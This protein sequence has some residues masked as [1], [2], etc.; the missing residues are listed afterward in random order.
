[1][2]VQ[3]RPVD[4]ETSELKAR[5]ASAVLRAADLRRADLVTFVLAATKKLVAT[6]LEITKPPTR[7]SQCR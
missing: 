4:A 7:I 3:A 2:I 1:L 5:L 6:S